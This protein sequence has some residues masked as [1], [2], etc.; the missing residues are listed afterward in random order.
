MYFSIRSLNGSI[1]N[2][3]QWKVVNT[4]CVYRLLYSIFINKVIRFG[5]IIYSISTEVSSLKI[6]FF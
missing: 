5:S 1:I 2:G 3:N 6:R 4:K